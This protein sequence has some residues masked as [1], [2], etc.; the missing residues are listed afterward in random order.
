VDLWF[1]EGLGTDDCSSAGIYEPMSNNRESIPM[2]SLF[3]TLSAKV[4]ATLRC[5]EL[6]LVK[7]M[8]R[9]IHI[10]SDNK[11]A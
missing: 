6:F 10:C 2:G 5:A 1:T 7:N 11:A 8:R 9:K 4:M 3:T